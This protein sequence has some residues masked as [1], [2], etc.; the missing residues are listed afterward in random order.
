[1]TPGQ[2][3]AGSA[4]P[5]RPRPS[6][7]GN[8]PSEGHRRGHLCRVPGCRVKVGADRLMCRPHWRQ[9]PKPLRD[10]IWATWRSGAGLATPAYQHAVGDAVSAV[11]ATTAGTTGGTS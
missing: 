10:Q 11:T 7:P 5:A 3:T 6:G 2:P 8:G 9:V 4:R 1:M